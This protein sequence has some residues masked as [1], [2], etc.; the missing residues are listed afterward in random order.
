MPPPSGYEHCDGMRLRARTS[1]YHG[2]DYA[3]GTVR[4]LR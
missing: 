1:G 2:G 3:M 4:C